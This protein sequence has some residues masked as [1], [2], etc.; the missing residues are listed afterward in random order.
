MIKEEEEEGE[1]LREV[2]ERGGT[3]PLTRAAGE[4]EEV[5]EREEAREESSTLFLLL[6][7]EGNNDDKEEETASE[8][9]QETSEKASDKFP[10]AEEE[11]ETAS[12]GRRLRIS[13]AIWS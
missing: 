13:R 5:E 3:A 11:G 1:F 9:E 6:G 4:K 8:G 2:D 12:G 7:E 10:K